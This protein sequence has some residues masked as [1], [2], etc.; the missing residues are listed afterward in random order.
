[1][2]GSAIRHIVGLPTWLS[3]SQNSNFFLDKNVLNAYKFH[4]N[5]PT[6]R[7]YNLNTDFIIFKLG[8]G[9]T[10]ISTTCDQ[11]SCRKRDDKVPDRFSRWSEGRG[12]VWGSGIIRYIFKNVNACVVPILQLYNMANL[13]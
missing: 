4:M 8:L 3:Y 12:G 1:M 7:L 5:R 6:V 11:S 9:M 2:T 10:N 13:L